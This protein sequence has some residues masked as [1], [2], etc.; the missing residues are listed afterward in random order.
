MLNGGCIYFLCLNRCVL[1]SLILD[2]IVSDI[3]ILWFRADNSKSRITCKKSGHSTFGNTHAT[4][5]RNPRKLHHTSAY[6]YN[7][8]GGKEPHSSASVS[9]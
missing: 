2:Q 9:A 7:N 1:Y 6:T 8:T 5:E 3:Y 4:K